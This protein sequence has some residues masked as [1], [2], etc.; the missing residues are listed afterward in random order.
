[1]YRVSRQILRK[2]VDSQ[3]KIPRKCSCSSEEDE[4]QNGM[5]GE[6]RSAEGSAPEDSSQGKRSGKGNDSKNISKE[7]RWSGWVLA[8]IGLSFVLGRLCIQ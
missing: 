7:G 6:E 4:P 5:V 2:A 1:M 3:L 8:D